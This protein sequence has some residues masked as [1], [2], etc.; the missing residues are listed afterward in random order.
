MG[1]GGN[2]FVVGG[3]TNWTHFNQFVK[4][5]G[6]AFADK[7]DA[8]KGPVD[9]SGSTTYHPIMKDVSSLYMAGGS[10]ISDISPDR[11]HDILVPGFLG[12]YDYLCKYH[13]A[14]KEN[15]LIGCAHKG[16]NKK[17][18][19]KYQRCL[20]MKES[21]CHDWKEIME[22]GTNG[23]NFNPTH[24]TVKHHGDGTMWIYDC[25]KDN[26]WTRKN[27]RSNYV[28]YADGQKQCLDM[29]FEP[30]A[31]AN[32]LWVLNGEGQIMVHTGDSKWWDTTNTWST[33]PEKLRSFC[34]GSNYGGG[35]FTYVSESG[36]DLYTRGGWK[37]YFHKAKRGN[38]PVCGICP[39]DG[40]YAAMG[41]EDGELYVRHDINNNGEWLACPKFGTLVGTMKD[42]CLLPKY[43]M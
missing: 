25:N 9:F 20:W 41:K 29:S 11:N 14:F 5:F 2:V 37:Q 15:V 19:D 24:V 43:A 39:I 18:A 16:K 35:I 27:L 8:F 36:Y 10:E 23:A 34:F 31:T 4:D 22:D 40:G 12:V 21:L 6:F 42:V 26:Y 38:I 32:R 33:P 28:K 13:N 17:T 30:W 3:T 1:G 7:R